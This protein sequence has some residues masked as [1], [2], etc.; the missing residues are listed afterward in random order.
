[1]YTNADYAGS[2]V[3]RR[4]TS[5]YC[6]FLGGNLITWRSKKH[7]VVSRSPAEAEFRALA[8]GLCEALWITAIL[9]KLRCPIV[10]PVQLFCDNKSAISIAH[11]P[12]Q[13]DRTKH[14]EIDRHFIK[15]KLESGCFC[16]PYVPSADQCADIFTK[17]LPAPR[18]EEL[19]NKLG[20][21]NIHAPA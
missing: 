3:N 7:K 14:I 15:E 9:R 5:G 8:Q 6:T 20:V 19:C 13:H 1:M 11:D 17:G 10:S 16:M 2:I 18:F 12:V 4:S 21:E